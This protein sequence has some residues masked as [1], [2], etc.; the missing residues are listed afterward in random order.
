MNNSEN[1]CILRVKKISTFGSIAGSAAHTFREIRTPNADAKRTHL[2][3]TVGAGSSAEVV[4][5]IKALL[6]QKRRKDAVLCLEY[7]ITASPSWFISTSGK[8]QDRFFERAIEWLKTRH[9]SK[10][11]VCLNCQLDETSPHLVAYIVPITPDGRLTAKAFIGGRAQLSV[12]QTDFWNKVGKPFGLIRG[13]LGST[14][15]HI[16]PKQYSAALH[17]KKDF[18]FPIAPV[19]SFIDHLNG[20]AEKKQSEYRRA[21]IKH[22]RIVEQMYSLAKLKDNARLQ[23]KIEHKNLLIKKEEI[24]NYRKELNLMKEK[25]ARLI[26]DA[27]NRINEYVQLHNEINSKLADTKRL[28]DSLSRDNAYLRIEIE[29]REKKIYELCEI[30]AQLSP[31][32]PS[33]ILSPYM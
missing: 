29:V 13:L 31:S 12:M 22:K 8:A 33:E 7:L 27:N 23:H 20:N 25:E 4:K 18:H 3:W 1:Y 21:L 24:E 5:A 10:N 19:I 17:E 9:N 28:I 32:K 11:I 14:A 15:K 26:R 6:P 2:N 30:V 16:S